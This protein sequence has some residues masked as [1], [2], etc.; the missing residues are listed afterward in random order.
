MNIKIIKAESKNI[1]EV[2]SILN[3]AADWLKEKGMPLWRSN[4][5]SP[6][7]LKGDVEKGLFYIAEVNG[8]AIGTLKFQLEDKLF[9]P[10]VP[11]GESAFI[12][13]IAVRRNYSGQGISKELINWAKDRA[14]KLGRKYLRLDV[15]DQERNYV[16]FMKIVDLLNIVR[17]KSAHTMLLGMNMK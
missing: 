3:E 17:I 1:Q 13:R 16:R 2:S 11:E 15:K 6:E 4:E 12:H 14:K 5:L 8:Q 10:D 9:W 7:K